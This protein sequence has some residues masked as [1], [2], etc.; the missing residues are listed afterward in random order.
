[1]TLLAGE[2]I[3]KQFQDRVL[4]ENLNFSVIETDRIGLVGPNGIGKTTLFE[5]MT[6]RMTPDAGN[7]TRS[8]GC[9]IAYLEQE[10][11]ESEQMNLF[12]FICSARSDLL[13]LRS[14]IDMVQKQLS[15]QPDSVDLLEKLGD[16]QHRFEASGGYEFETEIKIILIGLGFP[17]NRFHNRL[18]DFSGGEKNRAALARLLAGRNNLLLLD[19]PTNHL[20][21]ESTIWL[22]TYLRSVGKAY[23][24]VSHDRMFLSNTIEKVWEITGRKIDQYFNGF[25]KYLVERQERLDQ[26]VH[27]YKHQQE[28]IKRIED[29]IRR[30]MAG[31]KTKQAQ[32]R[33]KYLARIKRISLPQTEYNA[34]TFKVESSGRSF[35]LVLAIEAASFG[36]GHRVLVRDVN[37]N[38][39]RGD[40][41]GFIGPNGTGKTTILKTILGE[42]D[43]VDGSVSIGQK[44]DVAYFDQEL[45]ELDESNS[46]IDE[47]W[48]L[49]PL[50]EAGRLR[51]FLARF[52]FTGEN[53]FKKISVLSGGEKTKLSLAKLL[54]KPA[55]LLIFDEPTNHLDI[56]SRHALEEALK[57]YT[58][59]LVVVSHDRYFLDQVADR[60][61][62]LENGRA[63]IFN[64]NYS[65]YKEKKNE[66]TAVPVRK[67]TAPEKIQQYVEFKKLSQAK[68]RIKKKLRSVKSKIED[69]EKNLVRL[70]QDI[71][72]NI[73]R[74]D[75]QKLADISSE[76]SSI[77][78]ALLELYCRLEEL[79][80]LDAQ[81]SDTDG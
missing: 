73:P 2:N 34:P 72:F 29:F 42:M 44:V 33:Q 39:Y 55:N 35:N 8:K 53:V 24:I 62:S 20:D 54:F 61:L 74:S 50:I 14:E 81:Y 26:I 41:L 47:V 4:F 37:L 68:G 10:F 38:L 3:I 56:D 18:M 71:R 28:E 25:D 63:R 12:D 30:N 49:D 43:P 77:E 60:I 65:Y 27:L 76:K 6:G 48:N 22:E 45:S 70:D 13:D 57:N 52:G 9:S 1:M 80:K 78:D 11:G 19:E 59:T 58:G 75:W 15:E 16:C 21:I 5:I 79:E 31:Q 46:I 17:E 32:S 7:V 64:G 51:S 67:T 23:I 66:E 69:L 40:R 36:Y